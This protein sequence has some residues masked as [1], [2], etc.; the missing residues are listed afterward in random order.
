MS[1]WPRSAGAT[2]FT[3]T[4]L[5]V[6]AARVRVEP[7][8]QLESPPFGAIED[9]RFGYNEDVREVMKRFT[10]LKASSPPG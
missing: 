4:A 6:G 9:R 7:G 2:E 3:D 8:L 5:F 10:E 1:A